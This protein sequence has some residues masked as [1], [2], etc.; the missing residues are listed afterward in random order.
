MSK[1]GWA[2]RVRAGLLVTIAFLAVSPARGADVDSKSVPGSAAASAAASG[3]TP[4]DRDRIAELERQIGVLAEEIASLQADTGVPEDSL[5]QSFYGMGPGA[6]KVYQ[7]ERGLSVGGYGE[8]RFRGYVDDK[9]DQHNVFDALRAVL[10]V[11]YKFND[12]I[13]F[14]SEMEFEHAG[15]SGGGSASVEFMQI[16]F[17]GKDWINARMG[18]L[19]IPMGLVNEIHEPTFFYGAERPEAE[20]RIIPST[21]RENGAGIFGEVGGRFA[22]RAYAV[23]GLRAAGFDSDGLRGGRQKGSR[24]L[25]DDWAFTGRFDYD[26]LPGWAV[27][28]SMW[29]GDSG[30]NEDVPGGK[31]PSTLTALY[32]IHTQFRAYGFT[33]RALFTQ[34]F[35][36][37][38]G[39]LSRVLAL[40]SNA[41]VGS[42]S[43]G[44]YV[45]IAYDV[46]PLVL[47]DTTMSLEPFFRYEHV[48]TQFK[49]PS[50]L[51]ADGTPFTK[52]PSARFN[53][54][55]I[56]I[57]FK[58]IP[59]VVLK[60]DYRRFDSLGDA[61][62]ADQIQAGFGYV[63]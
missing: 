18:L 34:A 60:L 10:Y 29:I 5:L 24:A 27:G 49:I 48:D 8:V 9:G 44:G 42:Q 58:P 3:E 4:G 57:D 63:F 55:V 6:S 52:D 61:K 19:L 11:G 2:A 35:V 59:Q 13:V 62:L 33:L 45:T 32:E 56:G 43:I 53:L 38:A 17:L 39:D 41:P 14:N 1:T 47:P 36:D 51:A 15:T 12:R 37:Q 50:G 26:I 40:P 20:R 46:L 7:R 31:I 54:Y 25:A 21:W 16:D 22:Y 28:A 30:Q 23:N